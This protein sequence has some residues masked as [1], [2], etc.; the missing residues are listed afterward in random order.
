MHCSGKWRGALF[1]LP[2]PPRFRGGDALG[3][4]RPDVLPLLLRDIS[5]DLQNEVGHKPARQILALHPGAGVQQG[6]VQH[7]NVRLFPLGNDAPL[8]QDLVVVAPQP[9]NAQN[10]QHVPAPQAFE[11]TAVGRTP[12]VLAALLVGVKIAGWDIQP[13]HRRELA[14][15]VLILCRYTD[16]PVIHDRC[17]PMSG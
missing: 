3:L 11:H 15:L 10:V 8:F 9:V 16:I 12:E 7:H 2:Y 14:G 4:P 17:L 13:L 1:P 6:E 5:Q